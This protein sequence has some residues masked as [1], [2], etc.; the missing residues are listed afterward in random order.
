MP[1]D[2]YRPFRL[3]TIALSNHE[4]VY[5]YSR[6]WKKEQT[7]NRLSGNVRL[8]PEEIRRRLELSDVR[9]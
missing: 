6:V 4:H 1:N 5:Q 2:V 3:Q 7:N 8:V 9:Q